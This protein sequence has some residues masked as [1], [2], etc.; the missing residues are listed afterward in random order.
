MTTMER[1][2]FVPADDFKPVLPELQA[3]AKPKYAVSLRRDGRFHFSRGIFRPGTHLNIAFSESTRTVRFQLS[4]TGMYHID[5]Q[6]Y[7]TTTARTRSMGLL[8]QQMRWP[9]PHVIDGAVYLPL[10]EAEAVE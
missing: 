1:T 3:G 8:G 10:D 4:E 6:G 9:T 2:A 5:T 7:I